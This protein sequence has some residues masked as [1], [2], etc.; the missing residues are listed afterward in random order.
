MAI[1]QSGLFLIEDA[2]ADVRYSSNPNVTGAPYLRF[3]AAY[4]IETQGERVGALC[5][6]HTEP[7]HLSEL[8]A[9]LLRDLA[10]WIQSEVQRDEDHDRA[11]AVHRALLPHAL[12]SI[13]GYEFI[14]RC[15]PAQ[16][17]GGDYYDCYFTAEDE[18][19]VTL[20]D[21]MGKGMGAAMLMATVRTVLRL[22]ARGTDLA[23]ALQKAARVMANDLA[24]T[25][26]FVTLFD[27]RITM[28]TGDVE[29][30]DAGLGLAFIL[31]D[32]GSFDRIPVRGLPLGVDPETPWV[33]GHTQLELEETL[34]VF[35][36]GIYDSLGGTD[37]A[38]G[39]VASHFVG[40]DS[41]D[42]CVRTLIT[43]IADRPTSD[44]ITILA[45]RR[46]ETK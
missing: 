28:S 11:I 1:Q 21:V 43:S 4:P 31:H 7:R 3:F 33:A 2:T 34:I 15:I 18:L 14:G 42:E 12:P 35:S 22:I 27:A 17:V 32:N 40:H 38:F 29:Y 44:D 6:M 46:T 16:A 41:L 25:N 45:L 8:E 10:L 19:V 20:A 13:E 23:G 36:D 26:T 24:R 5:L 39:I 30:V 9:T 37:D